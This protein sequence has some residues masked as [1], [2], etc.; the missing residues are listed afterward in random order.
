MQIISK[1]LPASRKKLVI[2]TVG[3]MALVLFTSWV[4][5]ETTKVEVVFADNGEELA[6]KTHTKTVGELLK[7]LNIPVDEH[8]ALS[9]DINSPIKSGMVIDYQTANEITVN[10]D[11][12]AQTF[13]TTAATI[14]DFF[15]EEELSF[16]AHD[17]ISHSYSD[18]IEEGLTIT[19]DTAYEV[20]VEDG[21]VEK[22]VWTTGG[23]V[24]EVLAANDIT[25]KDQDKID[26]VLTEDVTE[27]TKITIV[28]VEEKTE[29]V[30][31]K[32]AF[33]TE[34]KKDATLE[35]GK[36]RVIVEGKEGRVAKEYKVTLENGEEVQR[37]LL[38]E[39]VVEK[40]ENKVVAIGTKEVKKSQTA[41]IAST[42]GQASAS[43]KELYVTASAYTAKC[44]GCSGYTATGINLNANPNMK[45]IAVD[46]NV[47]PLGSKVWVEGYGTAIAADTGGSIKGNRIDAHFPT[48][49]AAYSFG[50][51]KVKVK[52]LD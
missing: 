9:H 17:S 32:I 31:E 29:K 1:V 6:V 4:I 5:F 30:E 16:S 34:T 13:H 33:K 50:R 11:G 26:P 51:K 44:K 7:E 10:L 38:R 3:I 43:G 46:P 42:A 25:Y 52:I 12:K 48:K 19:I 35:K 47:I 36:E 45:V 20:T 27:N 23:K 37:E 21:S 39:E 22:K 41:S 28:H 2:S 15:K 40:S 14:G 18:V 24:A 49:Q 8:D